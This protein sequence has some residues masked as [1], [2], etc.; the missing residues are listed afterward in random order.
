[1]GAFS[2]TAF[3][4]AAF[5]TAAFSFDAV[6]PTSAYAEPPTYYSVTDAHAQYLQDEDEMILAII[7]QFVM[8]EA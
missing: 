6:T 5:S 8:E 3:A 4:I 2:A 1:M 7:Q